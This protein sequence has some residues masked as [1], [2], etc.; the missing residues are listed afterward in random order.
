[1]DTKLQTSFIPKK[2]FN[3]VPRKASGG[4]LNIIAIVVF[5]IAII[6]SAGV[7]G[8]QKLLNSKIN[9]M[10]TELEDAR[11]ALQPDVIKELSRANARF[12]AG[13]DLIK[14][15]TLITSLFNL[16]ETETLRAVRFSRFTYMIDDAGRIAIGM[17]GEAP[18]YATVALQS[19]VFSENSNFKGPQFSNLDLSKEGNVVFNFKSFIDTTLVSYDT[20]IKSLSMP[21]SVAPVEQTITTA[22]ATTTTP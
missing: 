22:P 16:L 20:F 7:Y 12:T 18:S 19:K 9:K 1:M 15:H 2:A 11:A 21:E 5:V 6:L 14:K 13:Q 4:L 17:T 8:Y 10:Q 3:D